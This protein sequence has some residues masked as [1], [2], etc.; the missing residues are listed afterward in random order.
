MSKKELEE[1]NVRSLPDSLKHAIRDMTQDQLV[2]DTLGEH[3]YNKYVEHKL[4]EWYEYTTRVTPWE[5]DRYL[6]RY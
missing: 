1:K 3:I 5:L 6:V 2:R 4:H